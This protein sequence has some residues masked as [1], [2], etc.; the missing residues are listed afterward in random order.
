MISFL[1]NSKMCLSIDLREH[2]ARRDNRAPTSRPLR[3]T[4]HTL[5][6]H[7]PVGSV[8]APLPACKPSLELVLCVLSHR[9]GVRYPVYRAPCRRYSDEC[10]VPVFPAAYRHAARAA[11]VL[12]PI[13]YTLSRGV[14]AIFSLR[15]SHL[16]VVSCRFGRE[17]SFCFFNP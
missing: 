2:V 4:P 10:P 12:S 14:L 16:C 9:V 7:L 17:K 3:V 15:Q 8:F 1:G 13:R 11:G 6:V 5:Y